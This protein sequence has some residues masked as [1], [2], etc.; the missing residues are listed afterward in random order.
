MKILLSANSADGNGNEP[1]NQ[2]TPAADLPAAAETVARGKSE[3]ELLLEK[4]NEKLKAAK[5]EL[6]IKHSHLQDEFGRFKNPPTPAKAAEA[7]AAK[8]N[9]VS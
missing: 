2:P 4:E 8:K 5:R 6:E 1:A 7:D 3:R 9:R